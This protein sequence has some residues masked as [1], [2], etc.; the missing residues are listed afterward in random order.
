[1]SGIREHERNSS[2]AAEAA[3]APL[4][5]RPASAPASPSVTFARALH[6][7]QRRSIDD[8]RDARSDRAAGSEVPCGQDDGVTAACASAVGVALSDRA[9]QTTL[10]APP[11]TIGP[12]AQRLLARAAAAARQGSLHEDAV[13]ES[14][15]T[16]EWLTALLPS[17]RLTL[18]CTEGGAWTLHCRA[19]DF[20][21]VRG[22]VA[23]LADRFEQRALGSLQVHVD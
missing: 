3:S 4:R 19:A 11:P 9:R 14:P 20:E 8:S 15:T 10:L 1:M 18:C 17:G 13:P 21:A 6:A 12:R 22:A 2:T 16:I 23:L 5:P 7:A